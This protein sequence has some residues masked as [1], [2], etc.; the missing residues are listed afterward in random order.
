MRFSRLFIVF[1]FSKEVK[2]LVG[3]RRALI[4]SAYQPFQS[5]GVELQA[6]VFEEV[7]FVW[8]IAIAKDDLTAKMFTIV[9]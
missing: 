7:R 5:K 3:Y 6:K 8:V 2:L 1:N 4:T 9:G